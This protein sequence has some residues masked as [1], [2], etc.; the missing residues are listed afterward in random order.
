[1]I[2]A[3]EERFFKKVQL[4]YQSLGNQPYSARPAS[5]DLNPDELH[6]YPFAVSIVRYSTN[7]GIN[8]LD[9]VFQA[10][11]KMS[12]SNYIMC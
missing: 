12:T 3:P 2:H 4:V 6:Q 8:L 5:V 10:K 9:Y 11:E 1:M 7:S